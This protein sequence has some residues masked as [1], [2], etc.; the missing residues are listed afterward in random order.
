MQTLEDP[1]LLRS[2][3]RAVTLP[4]SVIIPVR[5][6]AH[7]LHRCLESLSG[8]GEVYVIDSSTIT[9][10]GPKSVN[11]PWIRFHWH[12]TGSFSWTPTKF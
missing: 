11:G 1:R 9:V 7:N 6:E 3:S 12:T 5:N 2:T 10:V 8:A 4:V